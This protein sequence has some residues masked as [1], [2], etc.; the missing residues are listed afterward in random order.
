MMCGLSEVSSSSSL[1]YASRVPL[2]SVKKWRCRH[3]IGLTLCGVELLFSTASSTTVWMLL[4]ESS[5]CLCAQS[6]TPEEDLIHRH[7]TVRTP[8]CEGEP[9]SIGVSLCVAE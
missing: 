1:L 2:L 3:V 4:R 6:E 5:V 7:Q 8:C 9:T